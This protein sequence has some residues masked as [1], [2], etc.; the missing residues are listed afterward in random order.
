MSVYLGKVRLP[1]AKIKTG[2]TSIPP[3]TEA[4]L[5]RASEERGSGDGFLEK[6][7]HEWSDETPL[8][9]WK[10]RRFLAAHGMLFAVYVFILLLIANGK[11]TNMRQYGMP[12][13]VCR[14]SFSA[15]LVVHVLLTVFRE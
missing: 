6:R 12:Y 11:S 14:C 7:R 13:C 9:I 8:P 15:V 3:D 10:N 1:W 5:A 4:S 2:Y